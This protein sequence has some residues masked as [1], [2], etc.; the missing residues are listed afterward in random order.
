MKIGAVILHYRFWPR[1]AKC[2]DA[3]R[4]QSRLPDHI[5]VVDNCSGDE[6]V[7]QLRKAYPDLEIIESVENRGYAAGMN[8]GIAHLAQ[9]GMR[10]C[11]LLTHECVLADNALE[12]LEKRLDASPST[13]AVGPLI[14]YLSDPAVIWSAGG[15]IDPRSWRPNHRGTGDLV[16]D[17]VDRSP[18][19][20]QWVD[21]ACILFR[22]KA[23]QDAG[24][25]SER[26]FLY[27]EETEYLLKM[28]ELGWRVECVPS[29]CAW[30]EPSPIPAY[31][32]VRN[33]LEFIREMAPRRYLYR[34]LAATAKRLLRGAVAPR[35]N[36]ERKM[37]ALQARGLT[38][39]VRRRTRP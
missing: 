15:T 31:L 34:E 8:Q 1:I 36:E 39:F 5:L 11:L 25:L 3:L 2:L 10:Y 16:S 29:A 9:K 26:Y 38:D 12:E 17:W 13:G 22:A 14:G 33:Q 24:P 28:T 20:T 19:R 23:L 35:S 37:L 6:S 7:A 18:L 21:G 32:R 30:Q 27:Y 4:A